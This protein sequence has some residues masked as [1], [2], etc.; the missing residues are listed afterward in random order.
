MSLLSVGELS[1]SYGTHEVLRSISFIVGPG[2]KVALVGRNGCGKSTLLRV[3]AGEEEPDAGRVSLLPRTHI[4]YLSQEPDLS[5]GESLLEAVTW[6]VPRLVELERRLQELEARLESHPPDAEEL[7]AAYAEAQQEFAQA[8][9]PAY[10]GRVKATLAG[11][12]FCESD[13][14]LPISALS[15][16]QRTRAALAMLLLQEPDVL[17][18]D[19]PTNHLD[20][21][22]IE[23][24]EEYLTRTRS[25]LIVVSH[26]R[27]F[28]DRVVTRVIELEEAEI[29]SYPGNYTAYSR[30]R[31]ERLARQ[32]AVYERQL[33]QVEKLEEYIRRYGAG[34]RATMAKSRE[35]ALA[36]IQLERP[37]T[38]KAEMH[39]DL[40]PGLRSGTEV[41]TVERLS[42]SYDGKQLF[43]GLELVVRRGERV[44][45]VGPNGSGKTTLLRILMGQVHADAGH[46]AFGH[47]VEPGYFAQDLSGANPENTLLE[48]IL[49]A[50]AATIEE[51]RS[52]LARFLFFGDDVFKRVGDLSGGETNRMALAR[53]LLSHAN[54]LLLDEPTN[55]L[56]IAARDRL[57]EALLAF[58][59]TVICASH[60]RYLLDRIATRIV[61]I[62]GG[63]ARVYDDTYAE[64]RRRKERERL[65][66]E[67]AA[68]RAEKA[69]PSPP[70]K[71]VQPGKGVRPQDLRR[72]VKAME[73][74]IAAA[75]ARMQELYDLLAAGSTYTDGDLVREA[76][77]EYEALNSSLPELYAEWERLAEAAEAISAR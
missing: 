10:A 27:Y 46:F 29:H 56:D 45:I 11:L 39:L 16:G 5:A 38:R 31:E 9:G 55:H 44:G 64:Y 47:N 54:V 8:G 23:W 20:L 62:A 3:I 74:R 41:V 15:G 59:G 66:A 70:P 35:K 19:E 6:A 13:Y 36:R 61:E 14:G 1:K 30:I 58:P 33:Q 37:R 4:G 69:A 17:L 65:L 7:Y 60:D 76:H 2:E 73:A 52:L 53:L 71:R 50:G 43:S 49:D 25:A 40:T 21:P 18:L 12:G 57:E 22:A 77:A 42:K 32:Q 34:N 26:D 51:A 67:Q 48:E 68:A 75:E 63:E 28:L 72:A 24:L